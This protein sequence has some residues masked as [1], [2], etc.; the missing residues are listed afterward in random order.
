MQIL[1]KDK[2]S[3]IQASRIFVVFY[4][5]LISM[6]SCFVF[7]F[8]TQIQKGLEALVLFPKMNTATKSLIDNQTNRILP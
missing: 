6:C 5:M 8:T 2:L 4:G 3:S 1:I 7:R